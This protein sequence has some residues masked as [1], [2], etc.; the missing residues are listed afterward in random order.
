MSLELRVGFGKLSFTQSIFPVGENYIKLEENTIKN[1]KVNKE[2]LI[3]WVFNGD[4]E[5][6]QL[7]LLVNAIRNINK[8]IVINLYVPY[9]PGSRQDR[10]CEIGEAFNLKV[11][12]DL[13]NS[14]NFNK[15]SVYDPHSDVTGALVNNIDI[16]SNT[17]FVYESILRFQ[18]YTNNSVMP[19][20]TTLISPD[21]GANKKI[22]K[23]SKLL[24]GSAVFFQKLIEIIRADKIRDTQTGLITGTEILGDVNGKICFAVDDICSK[25]GTFKGL[26]KVAKEKGAS[27]FVLI[28]SH[29]EGTA[30]INS[31]KESGIDKIYCYNDFGFLNPNDQEKFIE[32]IKI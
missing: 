8:D 24:R 25:G 26:A 6:M 17:N 13:I 27:K 2:V 10:I 5:L 3:V 14:L 15:V 7:L 30:N 29:Y 22:F 4:S 20:V 32:R 12:A 28:V 16:C 23:L 1:V 31:L 21:A 11:Y 9:F 18:Y 19:E